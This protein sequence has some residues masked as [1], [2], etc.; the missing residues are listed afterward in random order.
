MAVFRLVGLRKNKRTGF[1][2]YRRV[3][4]A[5]LRPYYDKREF[6]R[7]TGMADKRE[8]EGTVPPLRPPRV[9]RPGRLRWLPPRNSPRR[10]CEPSRVRRAGRR[11]TCY[12]SK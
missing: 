10:P 1:W 3:P 11:L 4:P 5:H 9:A 6:K 2:E 12:R 7:S 8:A